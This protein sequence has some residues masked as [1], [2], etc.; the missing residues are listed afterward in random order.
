MVEPQGSD[1]KWLSIWSIRVEEKQPK[2]PRELFLGS[3]PMD[4][5]RE[6][7][8][9]AAGRHRGACRTYSTPRGVTPLSSAECRLPM[10]NETASSASCH[11]KT[12]SGRLCLASNCCKRPNGVTY[13]GP[14]ENQIFS[15]T[16]RKSFPI[17][18]KVSMVRS[19][20]FVRRKFHLPKIK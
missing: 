9:T 20:K 13:D 1:H 12:Y 7:K 5:R 16:M 17:S 6:C 4:W 8:G 11:I 10:E 14:A 3:L 2:R 15:L 19:V 18:S